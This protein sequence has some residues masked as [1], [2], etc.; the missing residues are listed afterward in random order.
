MK[1]SWVNAHARIYGNEMTDSLI[2]EAARSDG[3]KHGYSRI[4]ISAIYKEAAEEAILK[5]QE[6]LTKT[7]K[8]K[9]KKT[10]FPNSIGQN[11]DKN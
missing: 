3:T 9:A 11:R 6:Q 5:W 8:A 4:P 2:K 7:P 10:I 1:V